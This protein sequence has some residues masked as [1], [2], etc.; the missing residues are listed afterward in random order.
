M[1]SSL[2]GGRGFKSSLY[3]ITSSK[4]YGCK[5]HLQPFREKNATAIVAISKEPI[6][7]LYTLCVHQLMRADGRGVR[8][9]VYVTVE[10]LSSAFVGIQK[11]SSNVLEF[12]RLYIN[13]RRTSL[14]C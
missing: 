11:F 7:S 5:K 4:S 8:N 14:S 10:V 9:T 12:E 1:P 2:T 3:I 6:L 13:D